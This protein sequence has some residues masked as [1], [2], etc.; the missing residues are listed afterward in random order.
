MEKGIMNRQ[1][2]ETVVRS[3]VFAH[4]AKYGVTNPEQLTSNIVSA[5]VEYQE[6]KVRITTPN[7]DQE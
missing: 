5:L 7:Q 6:V 2:Y 1:E 3:K 4:T